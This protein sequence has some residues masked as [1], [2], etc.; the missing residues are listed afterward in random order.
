M[1][2]WC[3]CGRTA[4]AS[5]R[6]L[7]DGNCERPS[8]INPDTHPIQYDEY[9]CEYLVSPCIDCRLQMEEHVCWTSIDASDRLF[10]MPLVTKYRIEYMYS[11]GRWE[12]AS[13]LSQNLITAGTFAEATDK[14]DQILL[15]REG[16]QYRIVN[17]VKGTVVDRT[18]DEEFPQGSEKVKMVNIKFLRENGRL[19]LSVDSTGLHEIL[20]SIGVQTEG[21][22]LRYRDRPYAVDAVANVTSYTLSTE[23]LLIKQ[24]PVKFDL[25]ALFSKPPNMEALTKLAQSS[26]E[27]VRKILEHYQPIDIQ[28]EIQ[29]KVLKEI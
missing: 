4:C 26:F 18:P 28:V 2:R 22:P 19:M 20:D 6:I 9:V 29:K 25:S 17:V 12:P 3:S 27:Q 11:H 5:A 10:T 13:H 16:Y 21:S 7:G 1:P 15:R 23:T 8:N 14:L 24:Y